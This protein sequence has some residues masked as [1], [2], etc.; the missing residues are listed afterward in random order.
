MK[1][2]DFVC[3][4]NLCSNQYTLSTEYTNTICCKDCWDKYVEK[5]KKIVQNY[6]DT[7]AN[8]TARDLLT[9][10]IVHIPPSTMTGMADETFIRFLLPFC[11]VEKPIY[12]IKKQE[13]TEK[14]KALTEA[15]KPDVDHGELWRDLK[16][17]KQLELAKRR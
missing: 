14:L 15:V 10:R 1:L 11:G 5:N 7:N 17:M 16:K 13:D 4:C 9:K 2:N 3:A 12:G 6:Y 8:P